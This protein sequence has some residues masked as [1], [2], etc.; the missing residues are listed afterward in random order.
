MDQNDQLIHQLQR[1]NRLL[2]TGLILAG[3]ACTVLLLGAATG[4][5]K[6]A[7]FTELDVERINV[8]GPNG[9]PDLVIANRERLPAPVIDGKVA[10]SDRGKKPGMIFYNADGDENGGF[11]FDGKLDKEGKPNAGMH[12]SMDRY[13][14][15]QQLALGHYEGNG[16]MMSGLQVFDRGLAKDYA[17][18]YE[19][20]EKAPAGA[21]KDALRQ[22][23]QA[24]GGEQKRRLFVGKWWGKSSAVILAAADGQPRISMTVTPEG[25]A[26]LDFLDDQGKVVQHFPQ[27]AG[28]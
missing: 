26:S 20:Y 12:L 23:W 27:V 19:A 21:E 4:A 25:Q 6:H 15:D 8:V 28:K 1:Q 13:G 18:L 9:K 7:R 10:T 11:I 3:G 2:K 14:G 24:A 17:A 16:A 22:K 5:G